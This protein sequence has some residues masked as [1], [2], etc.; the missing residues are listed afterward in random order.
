[1]TM[2]ADE[3]MAA[4]AHSAA[5]EPGQLVEARRRQWMVSEV[6]G[7]SVAPGLPKRHLVRLA[8]IDEDALGE[9]IEVL[10]ELEPGA[11]VI[12]RAGLPRLTGLDD[13]ST[14][15]AFLDAV[16]WGAAT[17][18]DRGY[19]QAPFRSGVSIEDYQLDPLVRAIDMARTNLL[20]A[21]DVGL[22]KTIEAGLVIQEMLLRHRARTVLVLC[23]ASLQ[24]K[25]RVEMQEKFGLE[26][27]IVDTDYV[28]RLRRERGLH[29]NPWTSFPRLITSMDWAKQGEGLRLL[30]D[31]LP[32]HV[33]HPRKFDLLIIDDPPRRACHQRTCTPDRTRPDRRNRRR[34]W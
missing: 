21:D 28:K 15:Q 19:L 17:N 34:S 30:R 25:W 6:N 12:E 31:A 22:G 29:A 7:G 9:E 16:V 26:F 3:L 11:H 2:T 20:I 23:P 8:S 1:M 4:V 14:L 10:W 13:P 32:P 24:E 18:A 33:S 5:P 27:R